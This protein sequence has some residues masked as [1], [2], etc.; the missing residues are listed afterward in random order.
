[1]NQVRKTQLQTFSE[2]GKLKNTAFG[3]SN[4]S[5]VPFQF[6]CARHIVE[7]FR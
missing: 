7:T 4:R 2:N 6:S 1:M 3:F 5:F